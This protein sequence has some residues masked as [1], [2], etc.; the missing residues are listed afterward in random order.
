[1]NFYIDSPSYL[2]L[3]RI[4]NSYP[5]DNETQIKIET[6][7]INQGYLLLQN[8]LNQELDIN[9]YKLILIF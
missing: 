7:L 3:Q 8:R 9:Y 1:V 5:I 6:F 2:E 4:I